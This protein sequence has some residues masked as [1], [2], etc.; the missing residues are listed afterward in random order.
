[1]SDK[2][3]IIIDALGNQTK[4]SAK[5]PSVAQG[6]VDKIRMVVSQQEEHWKKEVRNRK[7]LGDVSSFYTCFILD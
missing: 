4:Y 1:M 5:T 2:A 7:I 3:F 6:W